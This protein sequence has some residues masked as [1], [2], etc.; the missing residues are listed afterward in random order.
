LPPTVADSGR[1]HNGTLQFRE[2]WQCGGRRRSFAAIGVHELIL[3][4]RGESIARLQRIAAEVI[5]LVG[6]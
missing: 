4:F 2:K 6:E 5:P 1:V 3:D